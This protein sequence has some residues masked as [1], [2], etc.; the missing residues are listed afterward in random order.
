MEI[1]P[2]ASLSLLVLWLV[3]H[4]DTDVPQACLRL[5]PCLFKYAH[6]LPLMIEDP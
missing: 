4:L 1:R 3:P 2:Y 5:F 6:F